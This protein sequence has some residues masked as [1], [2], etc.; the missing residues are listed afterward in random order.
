MTK[1][2]TSILDWGLNEE[3]VVY[4]PYWRNPYVVCGDKEILITLWQIPGEQRA[5]VGIYNYGRTAAKDAVIRIDL[6]KLGLAQKQAMALALHQPEGAASEF[7]AANSTLKLK[8]L[9][10]HRGI[11]IGLA[12]PDA[13]ETDRAAKNMPAWITGGLPASIVNFGL[14]RKETQHF[15]PSNV[16]AVVCDDAAIQIGMWQ[17]PDRILLTVYNTDGA[18]VKD[19]SV[20][21]DL[22]KLGLTPRLPWQDFIGVRN[23]HAEEKAPESILDFYGNTLSLKTIPPKTGRLVAIRRY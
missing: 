6:G 7:D 2:P 12:A 10:P 13:V 22:A 14:A 3:A 15:A 20:K 17:L 1:M 16:P 8:A 4:H 21:V 11:F 9:P 23:L 18:A 19:V 5:V